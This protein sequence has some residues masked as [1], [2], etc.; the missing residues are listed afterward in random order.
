MVNKLIKLEIMLLTGL[1]SSE[2]IS[3]TFRKNTRKHILEPKGK[4]LENIFSYKL[5]LLSG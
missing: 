5:C 3:R 2:S 1:R 4:T